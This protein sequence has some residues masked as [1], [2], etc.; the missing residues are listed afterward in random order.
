M[1]TINMTTDQRRLE[2]QRGQTIPIVALLLVAVLGIVGLAVDVGYFRYDQRLQQAAVDSAAT[3][4]AAQL[5]YGSAN[6]TAAAKVDASSNGYTDGVGGV[7]V[8]VNTAYSDSFTNSLGAVKVTIADSRTRTFGSVFGTASVPISTSA[9][10]RLSANNNTCIYLIDKTKVPDFSSMTLNGSGCGILT[11]GAA[12]M[13]GATVTASY[14]GYSGTAPTTNSSSRFASATPAPALPI[15]DPCVHIPGCNYLANN[16]PSTS[17]CPDLNANNQFH[18]L[19]PGCY[20]N[21]N[22]NSSTTQLLPGLFVITGL[23][24]GNSNSHL[25]GSG[26]TF[27]IASGGSLAGLNN[28]GSITWSAPITGNTANV[29]FYQVAANTTDPN[30]ASIATFTGLLYF[31]GAD[32]NIQSAIGG[33]SVLVAAGAHFHA[34]TRTFPSPPPNGAFV[35]QAS[36]AE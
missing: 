20:H 30:F 2:S 10:A 13:S 28:A 22:L 7:T 4:G 36:L 1:S 23:V 14:I 3:A 35:Q 25:T 29:L 17:S 8:T 11:A 33:Y 21:L 31:P 9:V 24:N 15:L 27:Y 19:N 16:P 18:T 12:N 5:A 6:A 32:V 34:T 26:V